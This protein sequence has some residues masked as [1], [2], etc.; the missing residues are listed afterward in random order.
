MS[1]STNFTTPQRDLPTPQRDLPT[2]QRDF[3]TPQ[4][5]SRL[6]DIRIKTETHAPTQI[7]FSFS[8]NKASQ[9]SQCHQYQASQGSSL[10]TPQKGGH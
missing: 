8:P 6:K 2:P 3:A 10:H 1:N 7:A 9:T 4:R 5:D